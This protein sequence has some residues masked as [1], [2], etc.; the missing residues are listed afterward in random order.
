MTRSFST[1]D[2]AA[3][4]AD[5]RD[6][7]SVRA[8]MGR[9]ADICGA[10]CAVAYR[11]DGGVR[12]AA[13]KWRPLFSTFPEEV[14]RYYAEQ[15]C[16]AVDGIVRAALESSAPVRFMELKEYLD[17]C[18]TMR[19]LYDLMRTYG[20]VDGL[21][22]HVCDRPGRLIYFSFVFDHLLDGLSDFER[23]RI[24]ACAEMLA[25]HTS[26]I[27]ASDILDS[28]G[29]RELSPQERAV[30]SLLARGESNKEIARRL[31][32]SPSTINTF[33]KRSFDKLG[34]R[35]RAEA[36]IAA[37]RTGLALVA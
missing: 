4:I 22:L 33:L 37:S 21:S 26:D 12:T 32:V 30:V 23:R 1:A 6:A 31:G 27:L 9:F 11:F 28:D 36:V 13:V 10:R 16:I 20:L 35:T 34:A 17:P 25:R 19:G 5:C 18:E 14:S 29:S 2:L 8:M 3:A 7:D 15:R 24:R